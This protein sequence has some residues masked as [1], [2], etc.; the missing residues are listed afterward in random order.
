[1]FLLNWNTKENSNLKEFKHNYIKL[2]KQ[3]CK[4]IE[5]VLDEILQHIYYLHK[6]P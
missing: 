3:K 1:M 2:G 4:I 6:P 5:A